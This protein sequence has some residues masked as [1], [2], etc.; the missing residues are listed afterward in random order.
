MTGAELDPAVVK[1]AEKA[2]KFK[3]DEKSGEGE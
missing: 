3:L 1:L 2:F